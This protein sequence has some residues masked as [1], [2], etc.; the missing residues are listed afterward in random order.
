MFYFVSN[1]GGES[2]KEGKKLGRKRTQE[3][4][5]WILLFCP[6]KNKNKQLLLDLRRRKKVVKD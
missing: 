6:P 2:H 4:K 1:F 3:K 5:R